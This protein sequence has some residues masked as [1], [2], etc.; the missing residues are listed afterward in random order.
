MIGWYMIH[1][2]FDYTGVSSLG[3]YTGFMFT[4]LT[5]W[6]AYMIHTSYNVALLTLPFLQSHCSLERGSG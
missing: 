6:D 4:V 3:Y 5:I 2:T 1:Q